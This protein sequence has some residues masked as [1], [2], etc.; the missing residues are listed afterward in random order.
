[1]IE[2]A[3]GRTVHPLAIG[4]A[5]RKRNCE[6]THKHWNGEHHSDGACIEP[7]GREPKR[8]ERHLHAKRGEQRGVED[9]KPQR[10]AGMQDRRQHRSL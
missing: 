5:R 8:Q 2:R 4:D 6:Q 3:I 9:R 10:K 7:L 1:M